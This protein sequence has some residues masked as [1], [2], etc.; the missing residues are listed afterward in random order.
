MHA[1][2]RPEPLATCKGE[3]PC[4]ARHTCQLCRY[5]NSGAGSC[6]VKGDAEERKG[7]A[8]PRPKR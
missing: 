6:S 2:P 3:F 1:G 7:S 4:K 8:T 5:C